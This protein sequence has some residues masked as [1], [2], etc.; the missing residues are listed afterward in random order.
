MITWFSLSLKSAFALVG[1]AAFTVVL[2]DID[3]RLIAVP[4]CVVFVGINLV[5]IKRAGFVQRVLVFG[6]LAILLAYVVRGLPAVKIR[7]F[8][9]FAP[10]G[11]AAVFSTAGFVFISFGGLLKTAAIAEEVRDPARTVPK[12]MIISLLAVTPLYALVIL[13]TSGVLGAARL[14]PSLTPISDGAAAFLGPGGSILLGIAAMLAFVST[15]NA[16]IMSA[17]RYPLALSRD[18]LIPPVFGRVNSRFGTPHVSLAVTGLFMVAVLFLELDTL[19]K[20]ASSVLIL[21]FMFSCLSV[22]VMR[23]SRL[24]NYQPR[25]R[26]PC[27]P[28]V[29]L[30][31]VVGCGLLLAGM[32]PAA[33]FSGAAL[34][35]IGMFVY[36]FYG[37]IRSTRE[38]AL[39]H[40]V[41]RITSKQLTD[42]L[43][44]TE[45]KEI[46]RERD[47]LSRDR[48]D[49]IIEQSLV[50]DFDRHMR[51]GEF[52][53][54]VAQ[55]VAP[56]LNTSPDTL[57]SLLLEREQESSTVIGPGL[58]IP[59]IVLPGER[60]FD[61]V[62]ARCKPGIVFPEADSDVHAVFLLAGSKDERNFHLR[63]LAAIAQIAQDLH[64]YKRWIKAKGEEELRDTVLLGK[65]LRL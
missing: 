54:L 8:E 32:G 23:E 4:L 61:I 33:L 36:W 39:L 53:K 11:L 55:A 2:S 40:L 56:R 29:Q 24:H 16:G 44:E 20:V 26:S 52:F 63:A 12:G 28:W 25:F 18:E 43:L 1:M 60:T 19:V 37:R 49:G 5:G 41:E 46:I 35:G 7:H 50:L 47:D 10:H 31:G 59:H 38:Y 57:E 42:R 64:F 34:V 13:V 22:I 3:I 45:L 27:Y 9:P 21:T 6:L 30:V 65:R 17:S 62:L 48:F 14:D 51:M 15:A 58:A